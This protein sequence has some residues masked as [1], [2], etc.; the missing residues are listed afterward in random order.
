[1]NCDNFFIDVIEASIGHAVDAQSK[2]N[3]NFTGKCNLYWI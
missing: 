2:Y 1:L 3:S